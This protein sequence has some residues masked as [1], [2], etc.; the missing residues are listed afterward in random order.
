MCSWACA[1][2][3]R[4]RTH[5]IRERALAVLARIVERGRLV[6]ARARVVCGARP[7]AGGHRRRVC[8]QRA[9]RVRELELIAHAYTLNAGGSYETMD[10]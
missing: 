3:L 4:Q 6:R 9:A 10:G 5:H 2:S 7:R 8:W 1:R